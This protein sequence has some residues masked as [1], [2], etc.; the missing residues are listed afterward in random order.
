MKLTRILR[1]HQKQLW[2]S[3]REKIFVRLSEPPIYIEVLT[4]GRESANKIIKITKEIMNTDYRYQFP[5]NPSLSVN[6]MPLLRDKDGLLKY[7]KEPSL[8]KASPQPL[9]LFVSG[10]MT[11]ICSPSRALQI[12]KV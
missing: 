5:D 3:D 7:T 6:N 4:D 2:H 9:S 11:S 12:R 1:F 10:R 8:S